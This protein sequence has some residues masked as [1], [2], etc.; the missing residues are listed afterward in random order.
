MSDKTEVF[1]TGFPRSGNTWLNRI[2][3][4]LF[5]AEMQTIPGEVVEYFGNGKPT[6]DYIIRKTHWYASQYNG[7]G[8]NNKPAKMLWIQRD[9]RDMVV[10]MMFYRNVQPDLMGV[11]DSVV[12]D[13]PHKEV[14]AHGYRSFMEGWIASQTYDYSTR[15]EQLHSQPYIEL[16]NVAKA[17][18]GNELPKG[19]VQ[20]VIHRQRFDRWAPRYEH[21]MR[22]GVVGDWRNYFK[23]ETGEYIT[24]AIGDLMMAEGYI[25][26]LDWWKGLPK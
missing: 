9:P 4:D 26:A 6:D 15:Y 21:S 3:S 5:Q 8:Y 17:V 14:G 18:T 11:L 23:Q 16:Q 1:I 19:F 2:C 20:G 7:K 10:S 12:W 24:E 25:N 22:K 13:R